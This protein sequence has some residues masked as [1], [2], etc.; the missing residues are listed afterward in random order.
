MVVDKEMALKTVDRVATR[1]AS[2]VGEI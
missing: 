2:Y 1:M